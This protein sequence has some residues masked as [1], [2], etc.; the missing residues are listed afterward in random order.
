MDHVDA[1]AIFAKVG[2]LESISGAARALGLPKANVSRAVARLEASYEVALLDRTARQVRLTEV[3][4]TLHGYCVGVVEKMEEAKARVAAHRGV[5]AGILR[6]GCSGD[7]GREL[8]GPFLAEFLQRYPGIDLRLRVGERLLPQPNKLDVVLHSGWLADSHLI[9]R[10]IAVVNTILVASRSY[11]ASR[12]APASIDDLIE[13]PV[14]GNFYSDPATI[15]PGRLPA[16][17]PMLE[18]ARNGV[19]SAVPIWKRFASTDHGMAL[20]LVRQGV[21]IAPVAVSR[22]YEDLRSGDLVRILPDYQVH[23]QATLYALY[24]DRT[25]M[26]PKLKVFI[27]FVT[28][29]ASRRLAQ[30]DL[31]ETSA[32]ARSTDGDDIILEPRHR[33]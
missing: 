5:P 12:G 30:L 8:V 20:V 29:I 21:A 19:R 27:E 1:C 4:R 17:V 2:D 25:A 23:D 22:I 6:V 11:V 24:A 16:H 10:K 26:A 28:E 31:L 32:A 3:G 18:L 7:V 14:I 33:E 15:D 9:V 13:H